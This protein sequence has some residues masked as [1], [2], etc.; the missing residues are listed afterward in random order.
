M[1]RRCHAHGVGRIDPWYFV[2]SPP[3]VNSE[4]VPGW[5]IL[6]CRMVVM[7]LDLPVTIL[8]IPFFVLRVAAFVPGSLAVHVTYVFLGRA[9]NGT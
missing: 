7:L 2:A 9:S 4:M 3:L 8:T 6:A 5:R 1:G